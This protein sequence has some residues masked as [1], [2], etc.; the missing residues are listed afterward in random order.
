M[1]SQGEPSTS[2]VRLCLVELSFRDLIRGVRAGD[3]EAAARRAHRH[4]PAIRRAVHVRLRD[5][6]PRRYFDSLDVCQSVLASVFVR[7]ALGQYQL[8]QPDQL[9]RLLARMARNKLVGHV[10]QHRAECRDYRR[11]TGGNVSARQV[12]DSTPGPSAW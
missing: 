5:P 6:R 1:Q 7:A 2:G 10:H 8:D 4:A 12:A 9:L 11:L 3:R